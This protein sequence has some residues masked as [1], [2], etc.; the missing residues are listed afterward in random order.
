M[1]FKVDSLEM[2]KNQVFRWTLHF[3]ELPTVRCSYTDSMGGGGNCGVA[4]RSQV[5]PYCRYLRLAV[6][7]VSAEKQSV[8]DGI[9]NGDSKRV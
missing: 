5:S 2:K 3:S 4:F 7:A 6:F 9:L 8:N 1:F